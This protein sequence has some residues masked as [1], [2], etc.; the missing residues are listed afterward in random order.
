MSEWRKSS[1]NFR[2]DGQIIHDTLRFV[3][4]VR[5]SKGLPT[6]AKMP[7]G[8]PYDPYNCPVAKGIQ[9][10]CS[11]VRYGTPIDLNGGRKELPLCAMEFIYRFDSG[12]LKQMRL[13]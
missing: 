10:T 4:G 8:H 2:S 9:D 1:M 5:K 7:K 6:L 3:N 12:Q 11:S 13:P